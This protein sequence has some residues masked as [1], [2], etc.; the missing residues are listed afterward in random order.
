MLRAGLNEN[1][2]R[3]ITELYDAQ[4]EGRI[5]VEVGNSERRFGETE[6]VEVFA[7]LRAALNAS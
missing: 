2:A 3:L 6:L 5:D 7:S 1:H 4:N